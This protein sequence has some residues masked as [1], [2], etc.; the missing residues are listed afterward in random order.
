M[1]VVLFH[2]NTNKLSWCFNRLKTKLPKI[3]TSMFGTLVFFFSFSD[4]RPWWLS[5]FHL[6]MCTSGS[7]S[8]HTLHSLRS[9][10]PVLV[11]VRCEISGP[12]WIA[13]I[14]WDLNTHK[15]QSCPPASGAV[16]STLRFTMRRRSLTRKVIG[17][18]TQI[19]EIYALTEA[20]FGFYKRK[21]FNNEH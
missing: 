5:S 15:L 10:H 19:C 13:Y 1:S 7:S 8:L 20:F 4:P 12:C 3:H 9:E 14:T 6:Q 16:M 17:L 11:P 2:S 18:E 21:D